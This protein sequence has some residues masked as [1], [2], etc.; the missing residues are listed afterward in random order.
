MADEQEAV[1]GEVVGTD[2]APVTPTLM[3]ALRNE[4][5]VAL[6]VEQKLL[7]WEAYQELT[8]KLLDDSDYQKIGR[9]R[10]KKKSAWRKYARA[11]NIS[12]QQMSEEIIRD[13]NGYPIFARIVIRAIGPDGR[14][15]DADQECHIT[16]RC[17]SPPCRKSEWDSHTCCAAGCSGRIHFSHPGDLVATA[18]TRAKNRAISD[19]IGAGEVSAEEMQ[20]NARPQE[21]PRRVTPREAQPARAPAPSSPPAQ[22]NGEIPI[23]ELRN[24]TVGLLKA[25]FEAPADLKA[26]LQEHAPNTIDGKEFLPKLMTRDKCEE[27]IK[28]CQA[29]A[30]NTAPADADPQQAALGDN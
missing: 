23:A 21:A 25:R 19:L 7:E 26:Y 30:E 1:E 24:Q 4:D 9:Q 17:C 27:I 20:D 13:D 2:L 16:E 28:D 29:A 3:P 14:H 22:S 10:F 5:D 6:F 15:Q 12:C 11:F 18:F 8:R